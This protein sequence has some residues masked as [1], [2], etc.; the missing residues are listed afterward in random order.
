MIGCLDIGSSEDK[1]ENKK[2]ALYI[3]VSSDEQR[4]EGLS[5]E[6]QIRRLQQ[7]CNFKKWVIFKIYKDEGVS[8]KSI[9]GRKDFLN[10]LENSKRGKFSAIL[11]TKIDRAFRNVKEALI[12]LD[13][14]KER[15]IDFVSISEDID[16]T[17]AM[18]KAMFTIISV[19]AELER[20]LTRDRNKDIM[21]DKFERGM[22]PGKAP[23]GYCWN[24]K[25]KIMEV[26]KRK[27]EIVK[28]AFELTSEGIGYR[29]ICDE[30]K[31]KP[32]SYY[33]IIKN[34]VYIGIIKF[35][36]KTKKGVH[37]PLVSEE[38]FNKANGN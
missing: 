18:G 7:Y 4:K 11:V 30:L 32:Q 25:K 5:I 38:L 13:E 22:M 8:G 24:K 26:D 20:S 27:S 19:F 35:E 33:N 36:N 9:K 28:K 1:M 15:K 29:K 21:K 34:K 2:V 16:T 3:R 17:T 6:A 10:M 12:T 14:L 31:L 37:E 23:F